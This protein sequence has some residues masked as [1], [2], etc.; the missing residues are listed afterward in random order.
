MGERNK[1]G[2]RSVWTE[3]WKEREC[4]IVRSWFVPISIGGNMCA[5]HM[6]ALPEQIYVLC[7]RK[8]NIKRIVV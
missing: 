8:I 7:V 4:G 2:R 5:R 3:R 1:R 6:V